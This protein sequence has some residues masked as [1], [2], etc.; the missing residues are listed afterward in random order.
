MRG[1][2]AATARGAISRERLAELVARD[3]SIR[4]IAAEVD[5]SA[6]TVRYWLK[7]YGLATTPEARRAGP[8]PVA[9]PT[10]TW[11]R[12]GTGVGVLRAEGGWRCAACA[13]ESVTR[14]RQRAKRILVEEAGGACQL[15]GYDRC[16]LLCS[17]CH[18]EVESGFVSVLPNMGARAADKAG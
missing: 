3:L 11:F 6:T 12:H 1:A 2:A 7:R 4:A 15:C 5:R 14:W 13:V 9:R 18:G 17:N 8:K 16:I 10:I